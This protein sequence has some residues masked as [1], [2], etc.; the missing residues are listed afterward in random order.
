MLTTTTH[1]PYRINDKIPWSRLSRKNCVD[2][3]PACIIDLQATGVITSLS[4]HTEGTKCVDR[5]N[6]NLKLKRSWSGRSGNLYELTAMMK[7]TIPISFGFSTWPCLTL[8]QWETELSV[9]QRVSSPFNFASL[10]HFAGTGCTTI[11]NK[12]SDIVTD[13]Q[14]VLYSRCISISAFILNQP[15]N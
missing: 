4:R 10:T 13:L 9:T 12:M 2:K 14:P 5:V 15:I 11:K 1:V 8:T 6:W 7:R 3:S